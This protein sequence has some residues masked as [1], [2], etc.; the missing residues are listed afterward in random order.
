VAGKT[1]T[2]EQS[3]G[4]DHS[5]FVGYA[6]YDDPQIVVAVIIEAGGTGA[7]AAAP[8]VCQAMAANL[9]FAPELCGTGAVAN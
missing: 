7:S 9:D 1:G 8:A 5:W 3:Q 6:P 4:E 2:A